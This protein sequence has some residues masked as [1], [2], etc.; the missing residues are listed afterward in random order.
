MLTTTRFAFKTLFDQAFVFY[1]EGDW[2]KAHSLLQQCARVK[3]T[4]GPTKYLLDIITK[5]DRSAP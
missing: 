1:L 4:D 2:P 5:A 3:S